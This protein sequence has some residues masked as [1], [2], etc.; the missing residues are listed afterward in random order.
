VDVIFPQPEKV[1]EILNPEQRAELDGLIT[2]VNAWDL[3]T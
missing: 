2:A 1:M 3:S